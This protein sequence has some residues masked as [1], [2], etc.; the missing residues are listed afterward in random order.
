MT[1]AQTLR[2][3][4]LAAAAMTGAATGFAQTL[5]KVRIGY[6]P[7]WSAVEAAIPFGDTLG[8]F[9]EEGLALEYVSVQGTAVLM[10]QVANGSVE[11]GIMSPDLAI[12]AAAKGETFPI[13]FFYNFYPRHIFEFTVLANS[14]IKSLAVL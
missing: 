4:L 13:K 8:Y 12:I 6:P 1:L 10:P 7:A 3:A 14:P 2:T 11:F 9:K 5:Q